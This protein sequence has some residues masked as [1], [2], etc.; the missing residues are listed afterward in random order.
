MPMYQCHVPPE[1]FDDQQ[2][3]AV[4]KSLTEIHCSVTGAPS[5]FVHIVFRDGQPAWS[6]APFSIHG[7][8]RSGRSREVTNALVSQMTRAL[9]DAADVDPADVAMRTIETPASWIME[10]G[11]VLPEPGAEAEWLAADTTKVTQ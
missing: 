1:R 6:D 10:G 11:R 2:R 7:G 3:A 9:A 8:I 4:A 5:T